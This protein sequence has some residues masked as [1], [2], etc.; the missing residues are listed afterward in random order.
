MSEG[1]RPEYLEGLNLLARACTLLAERGLPLPI[2][3][4]GAVVEFDTAGQIHTGDFDVLSSLDSELREAV[5]AVGFVEENRPGRRLGGFYHPTLPLGLEVVSKAYFDGHGDRTR[6]R[7]IEMPGGSVPM[8][9]TE[10]L[11]ADRLG[12]WIAS[13]RRDMELLIQA[14]TMFALASGLAEDYLDQRIRQDT[15]GTMTLSEFLSLDPE[16]HHP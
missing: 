9:P 16:A 7:L 11:I 14:K 1:Y 4:G 10:E 5:L 12:Q 13:D 6:I 2:L 3:V 15:A 8:A